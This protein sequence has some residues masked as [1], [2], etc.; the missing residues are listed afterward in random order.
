MI[1]V[2]FRKSSILGLA[3]LALLGVPTALASAADT[4]LQGQATVVDGRTL[5]I[6]GTRLRL[7]NIDAPDP[8]Q[9]CQWPNKEIDCG[10]V[11]RT[12]LLDLVA[13]TEVTCRVDDR[14]AAGVALCRAGDFDVAA[15]MLHTGWAVAAEGAPAAYRRIEAK[16]RAARRGL[17]KGTFEMPWIWRRHQ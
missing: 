11:A 1:N 5:N 9:P 8:S 12:A 3:L 17:W 6:G 14:G 13:G 16:A 4:I 7:A 15:N 10:N 2:R